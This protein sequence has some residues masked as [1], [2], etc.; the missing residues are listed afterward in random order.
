MRRV[1]IIGGGAVSFAVLVIA[2][3]TGTST[4]DLG[5]GDDAGEDLTR[6]E[7]T[8]VPPDPPPPPPPA[9]D[10]GD[11]SSSGG[12]T[13]KVVIN[14]VQT[15]GASASDE[16]VEIYNP[17]SCAVT[18]DGKLSYKSTND[19]PAA[20]LDM[21]TFSAKSIAAHA[22]FV[23]GSTARTGAK[24][25]TFLASFAGM[26]DDGQIALLDGTGKK[27][28]S[29]GFSAGS[30]AEKAA[31]PAAPSGGSAA[32]TPNGTDTDDNSKDFKAATTATPGASN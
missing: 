31:A 28:D 19:T 8:P 3:A 1:R 32:R 16:F 15:R 14:E 10:S 24:D 22:Y 21:F 9:G 6:K 30:Y 27:I 4:T 17:N 7:V 5:A 29:V 12:C 26:A 25:A 23:I 20:G 11:D 2:C 18:L 13:T